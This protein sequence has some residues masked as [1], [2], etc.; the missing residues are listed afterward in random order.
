MKSILQSLL[1]ESVGKLS[2]SWGNGSLWDHLKICS[3]SGSPT[4]STQQQNIQQAL[5]CQRDHQCHWQDGSN[6][7][8]TIFGCWEWRV[9]RV[10]ADTR[11]TILDCFEKGVDKCSRPRNLQQF[12]RENKEVDIV[13]QKHYQFQYRHVEMRRAKPRVHESYGDHDARTHCKQ[14]ITKTK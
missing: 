11:A 3:P 8:T 12:G 6:W 9:S 14:I 1:V 7:S 2:K 4:S 5:P 10:N 13:V